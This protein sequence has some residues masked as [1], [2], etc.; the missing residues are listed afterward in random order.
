MECGLSP[1]LCIDGS[2]KPWHRSQQRHTLQK[3]WVEQR[4][5][6]FHLQPAAVTTSTV[7]HKDE[8]K[9]QEKRVFSPK[10]ADGLAANFQASLCASVS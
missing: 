7:S 1:K 10:M 6:F 9:I 8:L 4:D 3:R 5:V 2:S